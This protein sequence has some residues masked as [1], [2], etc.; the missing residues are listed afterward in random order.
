MANGMR[1]VEMPAMKIEIIDNRFIVAGTGQIGMGQRFCATV[2]DLWANKK[3]NGMDE[4]G[5]ARTLAKAG[6]EDFAFTQAKQGSY[7]AL[8]AFPCNKAKNSEHHLVEFAVTDFQ[9]EFKTQN[10]WYVS[11]GSGQA[12]IDPFLCFMREIFWEKGPP[13]VKDG[14]FAAT[15]LLDYAVTVN[16]GGVN[17]PVRIATLEKSA[18]DWKARLLSDEDLLE[19]RE[20]QKAAKDALRNFKDKIVAQATAQEIPAPPKTPAQ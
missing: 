9:P 17:G 11:M 6:V 15:W 2:R 16:T 8:V 14:V 20:S 13:S 5:Y 1:T 18:G 10:I 19:H 12:V 4:F 7:G 3:L